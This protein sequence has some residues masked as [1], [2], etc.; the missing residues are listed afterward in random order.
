MDVT[1]RRNRAVAQRS[2]APSCAR[3][4]A[5]DCHGRG[6]PC[7]AC[8]KST[9]RSRSSRRSSCS[10]SSPSS[11]RSARTTSFFPPTIWRGVLGILPEMGL[12]A[13]GVTILMICG[14]FDLSVGS[15]FALMPMSFAIML[16]AG[17]P[18]VPAILLGLVVSRGDRLHQRLRHDPL[19]HPELHRHARHAVHG[20][21]ADGG[22]LGRLPAAP[23]ARCRAGSSPNMSD[24]A[25]SSA[26]P[27]SGSSA[28]R[29]SPRR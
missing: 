28:S 11:S 18:F 13:I 12:V 14:E 26:C 1:F 20:A 3:R 9:W 6:H 21:L 16:N 27:S 29:C 23:A 8:S 25:A 5:C 22:D 19:R 2:P 10:S 24:R 7:G 15:V 17:V 4:G